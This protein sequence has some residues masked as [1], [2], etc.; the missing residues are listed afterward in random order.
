MRC[1][2]PRRFTTAGAGTIEYIVD[3]DLNYYFLEMNTRLQVEHPVTEMI[4]GLDLVEWQL[5]VASGQPLPLTQDQ[6][7]L[8]G[9]AIEARLYTEDPYAGFAP[10]D[11]AH[12]L[13]A[14]RAGPVRGC[15]H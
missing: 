15:A 8:S 10:A 6:I 5:R 2:P 11:R 7:T 4:S 12:R 14:S 3:Q 13:V 1:W 9:H